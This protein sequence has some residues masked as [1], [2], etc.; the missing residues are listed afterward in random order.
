MPGVVD[1]DDDDDDDFAGVAL[2]P[3]FIF[4]TLAF[5]LPLLLGDDD[6][7]V[8]GDEGG[9]G[10][11]DMLDICDQNLFAFLDDVDTPNYPV[12]LSPRSQLRL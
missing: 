10:S 2:V 4:S 9:G 7:G 8:L 5:F 3:L 1:D 11:T 12:Y 6:M